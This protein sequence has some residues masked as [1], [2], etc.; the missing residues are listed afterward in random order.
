MAGWGG[1]YSP[2]AA[3]DYRRV[4]IPSPPFVVRGKQMNEKGAES[5]RGARAARLHRSDLWTVEFP[6]P[7][8]RCACCSL[9]ESRGKWQSAFLKPVASSAQTGDRFRV[10]I[11]TPD[12]SSEEAQGRN[13]ESLYSTEWAVKITTRVL[14]CLRFWTHRSAFAAKGFHEVRHRVSPADAPGSWLHVRCAEHFFFRAS[15]GTTVATPTTLSRLEVPIPASAGM[16]GYL[17]RKKPS[18]F[19]GNVIGA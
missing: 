15:H 19:L 11:T 16:Q 17:A 5:H 4:W 12:C 14:S 18:P 1:H 8:C 10:V 3:V 6:T 2:S 9:E 13:R 7:R